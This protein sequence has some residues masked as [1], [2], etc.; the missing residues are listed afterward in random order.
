[1]KYYIT[2]NENSKH[3]YDLIVD[4]NNGETQVIEL[5]RKTTD[6]YL[7]M[8]EQCANETNRRLI[9]IAMIQKANVDMF[10]VMPREYR[11]P[12]KL[13]TSNAQRKGLEE[14]LNEEDRAIFLALIEKAKT[15]REEANKKVPLSPI[16]KAQ[17]KIAQLQAKLEEL[18]AQ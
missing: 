8:P 1:M 18:M 13:S 15:A 9:S 11:E 7:H 17:R 10:E 2:K 12:R 16:E 14:Y 5:T 4:N 6:N 3:G